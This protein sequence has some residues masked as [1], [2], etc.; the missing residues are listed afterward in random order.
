[1]AILKQDVPCMAKIV[2]KVLSGGLV[3]YSF[4]VSS[5][6]GGSWIIGKH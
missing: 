1:M 4:D 6:L 5:I 2:T 3:L